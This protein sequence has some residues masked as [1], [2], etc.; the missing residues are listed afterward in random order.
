MQKSVLALLFAVIS[1]A[2]AVPVPG[3]QGDWNGG[4]DGNQGGGNGNGDGY[5][6]QGGD[7]GNQDYSNW[8]LVNP[9]KQPKLSYDAQGVQIYKCNNGNWGLLGAEADLFDKD[10]N[11]VGY[12][13]FE[14]GVPHWTLFSDNSFVSSRTVIPTPS[15][16]GADNSIAWLFAVKDKTSEQ[17]EFGDIKWV[18]RVDTEQGVPPEKEACK[19]DWEGTV[20]K[21]PYF[22]RYLF[23][24]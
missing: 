15:P 12:H 19:G 3:G 21:S 22:A 8:P 1:T 5:G 16:N 14:N 13:F 10:G 2:I 23:Q 4:N 11:A 20:V 9:P 7:N 18:A 24:N 6:N 17:G